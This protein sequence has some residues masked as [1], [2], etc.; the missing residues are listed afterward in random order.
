MNVII[1]SKDNKNIKNK[2]SK[3]M[4]VL[5]IALLLVIGAVIGVFAVIKGGNNEVDFSNYS[6]TSI[7]KAK[8]ITKE[9]VYN[10]TG[11][12]KGTIVVDAKDKNVKLVLNN[13]TITAEEGPAIYVKNAKIVYIELSGDNTLNGNATTDLNGI[14]YAKSDLSIEGDGTIN[15]TSN[16]DGIVSKDNLKILS[17]T[18]NIKAEDD[19]IVGKDSVYVKDGNLTI[20]SSHDGIKASNEKSGTIKI[21]GGIFNITTGSGATVKSKSNGF[22]NM[23]DSN[24]ASIKGIKAAGNIEIEGGTFNINSEDDS[25]HSNADIT[26]KGGTFE[27]ESGDD[28]LHAD[29]KIEISK[30]TFKITA[31]EGIEA[32]YVKI[33]GGTINIDASDDGINAANKS[34]KYSTVAEINGGDITIKM[35]SGDTDGIDSNGDLYIN[36]GTINITCNSPF[37]YDGTAKKTGGK[38]IINGSET[39]TITNQMMGPQG[40]GGMQGGPSN[41][42]QGG[43]PNKRGMR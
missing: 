8:E 15:I 17:G 35:A 14:I 5:L 25:I 39:D 37:D 13:A 12:I 34:N 33:D 30:G 21:E 19:G 29:G 42:N 32:T 22:R 26:I 7:T 1:K 28:G 6:T 41:D 36:G 24:S 43:R 40:N 18:Y 2:N 31:S 38:L 16:K 9:G 23:D 4:V 11:D 27:L 20:T 3:K 10:I